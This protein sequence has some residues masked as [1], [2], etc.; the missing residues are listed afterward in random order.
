LRL[1]EELKGPRGVGADLLDA[2]HHP[3]GREVVGH[4]LEH[5]LAPS[6]QAR[7]QLGCKRARKQHADA[8]E[9]GASRYPSHLSLAS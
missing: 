2:P 3:L 5:A 4:L 8:A 9:S 1:L 6:Q 7:V